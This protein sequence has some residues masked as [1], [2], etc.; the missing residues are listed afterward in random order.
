MFVCI[1]ISV[2]S[3]YW[4]GY[5][6]TRFYVVHPPWYISPLSEHYSVWAWKAY[7]FS[8]SGTAVSLQTDQGLMTGISSDNEIMRVPVLLSWLRRSLTH[9]FFEIFVYLINIFCFQICKWEVDDMWLITNEVWNLTGNLTG[10]WLE[11]LLLSWLIFLTT[12]FLA[13]K[14][15]KAE[16]MHWKSPKAYKM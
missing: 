7:Y 14:N 5:H 4:S 10:N 11:I 13:Q 1:A 8:R 16:K 15:A 12:E 9:I 3:V 6:P 2:P